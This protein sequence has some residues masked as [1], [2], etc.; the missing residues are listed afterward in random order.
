MRD[1]LAHVTGRCDGDTFARWIDD[2]DAVVIYA[3]DARTD[4]PIGFAVLTVPDFPI[5]LAPDDIELRRIY[6]LAA[7]HGRGLGPA[8][9]TA[10]RDEA[11]ARGKRRML[12]GTHPENL[13][14][15]RF[16][17]REG[18]TLVGRRSFRIG[19]RIFDDPVYALDL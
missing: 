19:E 13:R 17:E 16:Y 10:A 3:G 15:Q 1:I 4:S 5:A 12:L 18:F 7:T 14:A 11:R 9:L 8:L 6:T 2:P